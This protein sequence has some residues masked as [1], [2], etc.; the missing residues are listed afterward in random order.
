[1]I[2][3]VPLLSAAE[4][5]AVR[6]GVFELRHLWE[7]RNPAGPF[8]TLGA[9][10]YLDAAGPQGNAP[11]YAKAQ[12]CNPVLVERFGWLYQRLQQGLAQ[13]LDAPV[14]FDERGGRPGFHIFLAAKV[15][16]QP[17]ASIHIDK[18]Y[19]LLDWSGAPGPDFER[20]LSFTVG[21][22]LPRSGSGLNFWD[23]PY[24]EI[25]NMTRAQVEDLARKRP[26]EH[27]PY[28]PGRL[29]M[30]SGHMVHQIAPSPYLEPEEVRDARI[31]LQGHGIRCG[32]SWRIYW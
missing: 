23:T 10:S 31:T 19:E 7:H 24:R 4:C 29:V 14:V 9:A 32:E 25:C 17:V 20:P 22:V 18:Q 13:A 1:M 28:G 27:H 30:H 8:Y 16:E 2:E 11:Y 6:D 3:D 15:F 12:R 21:I 5:E 26:H